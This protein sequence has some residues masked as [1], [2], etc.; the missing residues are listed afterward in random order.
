[1]ANGLIVD[2]SKFMRKILRESL[3]SGNHTVLA[4][5]DNGGDG[6]EQ[7]K[8]MKPDFVTMDITMGGVDGM[9][10]VKSIL[11]HDPDAKIIIISALN[12]KTIKMNDKNINVSAFIQKPFDRDQLLDTIKSLLS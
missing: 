2:D 12:E 9:K 3:E 1:M 5:A 7:Y 4:E 8:I 10:A 6:V 11:E